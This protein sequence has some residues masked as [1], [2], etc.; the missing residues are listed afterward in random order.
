M[1]W[2]RYCCTWHWFNLMLVGV[3]IIL[4]Y[5]NT[6]RSYWPDS[7]VNN[8]TSSPSEVGVL[9]PFCYC[10]YLKPTLLNSSCLPSRDVCVYFMQNL[11]LIIFHHPDFRWIVKQ[12]TKFQFICDILTYLLYQQGK[13]CMVWCMPQ[14]NYS[15]VR[16]TQQFS[17]CMEDH[18]YRSA[19]VKVT[20]DWN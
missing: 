1:K 11:Q 13:Y 18:T 8:L 16:S 20:F 10:K 5:L 14:Q 17:M 6:C 7:W 19:K 9:I 15:V 4:L 2:Q 12:V 3:Y